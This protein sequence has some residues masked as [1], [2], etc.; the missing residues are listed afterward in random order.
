MN[1]YQSRVF[2]GCVTLRDGDYLREQLVATRFKLYGRNFRLQMQT[3]NL[4]VRTIKLW[5]GI[6]RQTVEP[7][8]LV[9]QRRMPPLESCL[10]ILLSGDLK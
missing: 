6:L 8:A 5:G 9:S 3:K 2:S 1:G 4:T 7:I 10:L